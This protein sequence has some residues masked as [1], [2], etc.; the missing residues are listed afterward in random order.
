MSNEQVDPQSE[1]DLTLDNLS[2]E[3]NIGYLGLMAANLL[4]S[5]GIAAFAIDGLGNIVAVNPT[6]VFIDADAIMPPPGKNPIKV[7][8]VIFDGRPQQVAQDSDGVWWEVSFED[9]EKRENEE[10]G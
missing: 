4:K 9:P 5:T 10:N 3:N 2:D 1:V 7:K 6:R 8:P